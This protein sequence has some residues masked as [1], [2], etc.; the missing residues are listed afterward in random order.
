MEAKS[1]PI[2]NAH[3]LDSINGEVYPVDL[4]N[5][6]TP[7]KLPIGL[8]PKVI[9]RYAFEQGRQMGCDPVGLAMSALV[10]CA[11]AI[12][13]SLQIQPKRYDHGWKL[14]TRLWV[15]LVGNVSALKSPIMRE[16]TRPI[17]MID[18]ELA[19]QYARAR[20]DYDALPK[21]ERDVAAEPLHVRI[22]IEDTTPEAAQNI[23]ADSPNGVIMIR[24][25]LSGWF[26]AMEKYGGAGA[27]SDRAFYLTSYNGGP[28]TLDRVK[29]GSKVIENLSISLLGG[30]QPDLI[31]QFANAGSDDG[32]IQR[33]IPIMLRDS[34]LG[35]DAPMSNEAET[36]NAL[37]EKLHTLSNQRMWTVVEFDDEALE[38]RV[39]CEQRVLDIMNIDLMN[40]KIAG[41]FGKY[42]G[43]FAQLCLLWHCIEHCNDRY[44]SNRIDAATAQ[45]VYN[46][47]FDFL[48]PHAFSFYIGTLGVA[49]IHERLAAVAGHILA[50]HVDDVSNRDVVRGTNQMRNLGRRE[51]EDVFYQLHALGWLQPLPARRASDP[52]RWKVNPQVHSLYAERARL[53]VEKRAALRT[54]LQERTKPSDSRDI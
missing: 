47:M 14:S 23:L 16:A 49:D 10:V 7:P 22:K 48:E 19:R 37:V 35:R 45:R 52:P 26:G 36:Y 29:R 51:I 9:E 18:R 53:E 27:S 32:L 20:A 44:P 39:R 54:Q 5:K 17:N 24:D 8:L 43:V 31:R 15:A 6:F 13:D 33:L 41:H 11:A 4:W 3:V 28:Y 2:N 1:E 21:E 34:V 46:F 40:R 12:P 42:H 38:V 30:I 50:H 25:E